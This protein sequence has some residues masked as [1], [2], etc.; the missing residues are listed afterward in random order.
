MIQGFMPIVSTREKGQISEKLAATYLTGKGYLIR[1]LNFRKRRGEIDIVA[2]KEGII[3]FV[4]VKSNIDT[5]H[6]IEAEDRVDGRKQ[7]RIKR[8]ARLYLMS[9]HLVELPW[10]LDI[11]AIQIDSKAEKAHIKHFKNVIS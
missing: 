2:E 3:V 10:Q 9:N 7:G 6:S 8:I 4:E 11:V 5:T 1:K